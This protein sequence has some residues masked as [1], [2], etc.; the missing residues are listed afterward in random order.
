M[1]RKTLSV[2]LV[3]CMCLMLFPVTAF[4]A[5]PEFHTGDIAVINGIIDAHQ[6]LGWVKAPEDGSYVPSVWDYYITWSETGTPT[7][8]RVEKLDFKY[9]GLSETLDVSGLTALTE[10]YCFGNELKGLNLN[11]LPALQKLDCNNNILSG[12]L[13]VSGLTA[14]TELDCSINK[15]IKLNV[16]GL[17][18]LNKLYCFAN[19][20][21][22][23]LDVSGLTNLQGLNC[24]G[25]ELK[26]LNLSNLPAIQTLN[27]Y[28]NEL[29]GT[30]DV[31]G[32]TALTELDCSINKLTTLNVN[33]LLNLNELF[34]WDN[35]LSGTLDLSGLTNLQALNC[36]NNELDELNLSGLTNLQRLY[37]SE[38]GLKRFINLNDLTALQ[39]L[40]CY[41]NELSGTLD[42]SNLMPLTYLDCKNNKLTK[43]NV[44]GLTN[45]QIL[46]CSDNCLKGLIN[47]SDLTA[48]Q[49]LE[50]YENELS[51]TLDVSGLKNL[52][53]LYC[54]ENQ[55]T[56]LILDKVAPY[57]YIYADYN[58]MSDISDVKGTEVP[59]DGDYFRFYPQ[60]CFVSFTAEQ[61]GGIKD[62]ADSTGIVLNFDKDVD[63]LN[64]DNYVT[65]T[66]S[67]G[68]VT[69][70]DSNERSF[71]FET[72]S[73]TTGNLSGSGKTWLIELTEVL[74]EGEV[75]VR[76][77]DYDGS[78]FAYQFSGNPQTVTVYKAIP[79][80]T[81]SYDPAGGRWEDGSTD[82]K[83]VTARVGEEITIEKAPVKD[84]Y[85][86][87]YWEGSEYQPGDKYK[88]PAG[89]HTFTAVWTKTSGTDPTG[90]NSSKTDPTESGVKMT[91]QP[92]AWTK[93][94]NEPASFT[95]SAEFKDFLYVKVDGE[96]VDESNY[97][98]KEG[99][100][101]VTFKVS[102]LETLSVGKHSVEIVSASG[103]GHGT[104]SAH[105]TI[106]IKAQVVPQPEQVAQSS[107]ST[108][109]SNDTMPKTGENSGY[110]PWLALLLLS[111]SGLIFLV[112]RKRIS[113]E[114]DK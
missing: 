55:L 69:L 13:D 11:N 50:C 14:L 74:R 33:G 75:S 88:V 112:R 78:E 73:V 22:G 102:Y 94:S 25:N 113:Q 67:T 9:L 32:L 109:K 68:S 111:A 47:L 61:T 35:Q 27:C 108:T 63:E 95:S 90:T 36:E 97:D 70:G 58:Y 83:I 54:D 100:T 101:I 8:K 48:L 19:Q 72:G 76:I 4:A 114:T 56:G 96:I 44:S 64:E 86:F 60:Y 39:E 92:P 26:G 28:D 10:L 24:N 12:T 46:Y 3:L 16:N 21:S 41:E 89:G 77:S 5:D 38:N 1:K 107:N 71:S 62:T 84:G 110:Y 6:E 45:L 80:C 34:C 49:E 52:E 2:L 15:L 51:G 30:L 20:L 42:V 106:E 66:D 59:W 93:S 91:Q 37:C 23:T 17:L 87:Q 99:S 85:E 104:I 7:G 79:A 103:S 29:S 18:N 82:P 53:I 81:V 57:E 65:V 98:V 43:L 105:G 40:E 31:S